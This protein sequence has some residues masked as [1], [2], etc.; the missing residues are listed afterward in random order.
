ML[1]EV[2]VDKLS[3]LPTGPESTPMLVYPLPQCGRGYADV[4]KFTHFALEY[5]YYII[6]I[7]IL[8]P[9]VVHLNVLVVMISGHDLQLLL[10]HG[11]GRSGM[12]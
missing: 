4:L 2:F 10:L 5:V 7:Y 9:V 12:W 3:G 6:Y 8:R 11:C 1:V